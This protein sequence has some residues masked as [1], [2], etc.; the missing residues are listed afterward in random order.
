MNITVEDALSI[1]PL[2]EGKLIA[3][4]HGLKR[5]VKSINIMDAPDIT[6]WIHE[7]EILFTTAYLMKDNPEKDG[8]RLLQKLVERGSAGLGIKLG[9]FWSHIPDAMLSEADR[10]S[11]PLI[12]LPF[13]FTFSDQMKGLFHAELQK[14][15]RVLHHI[16]DQQKEL[17]RITLSDKTSDFFQGISSIL[18]C[19]MTIIGLRGKVL[20]NNID[21]PENQLLKGWPWK[22]H[23]QQ[24]IRTEKGTVVLIPLKKPEDQAELIGYALFQS[25][26]PVYYKEEEGLFHQAADILA[27]HLHAMNRDFTDHVTR[28]EL[29]FLVN[30]YLKQKTSLETLLECASRFGIPFCSKPYRCVLTTVHDTEPA[31]QESLLKAV[32][33]EFQYHPLLKDL[34]KLHFHVDGAI[35]SIFPAEMPIR[36]HDLSDRLANAFSKLAEDSS[37]RNLRFSISYPKNKA[38]DLATAYRE[39]KDTLET[40]DFLQLQD[41]VVEYESVEIA[42]IFQSVPREKMIRFCE[43]ILAPLLDKSSDSTGDLLKTLELYIENNGQINETAKHLFIHRNTA[44]YRLEKISE[45]LQVDFKR[46][47]DVVK[48]KLVL[49]F[50]DTLKLSPSELRKP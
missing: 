12:E 32:R 25:F 50:R 26:E 6:D 2:S 29:S 17:F 46:F 24:R 11:F 23:D 13:Q 1:Y 16:L 18:E 15:N 5:I 42:N 31:L 9:R 34:T 20:F 21:L 43:L 4:Q 39:C 40:A 44:A 37:G 45:L 7:G 3:G 8:T 47:Q 41:R 36:E 38:E 22:A 49:L 28:N 27:F 10:L 19:H 33:Q 30:N 48:I 14:S 35:F